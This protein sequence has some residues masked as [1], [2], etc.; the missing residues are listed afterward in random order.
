MDHPHGDQWP[1]RVFLREV[2]LCVVARAVPNAARAPGGGLARHGLF[3]E[4][5]GVC[6]ISGL[7]VADDVSSEAID[8]NSSFAG[9]MQDSHACPGWRPGK[10]GDYTPA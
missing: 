6:R 5:A 8:W 4:L 3:S 9:C 2:P 7:A 10:P 1:D